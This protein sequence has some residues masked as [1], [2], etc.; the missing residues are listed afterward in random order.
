MLKKDR[1]YCDKFKLPDYKSGRA[2]YFYQYFLV[3][4]IMFF[5][6]KSA[7]YLLG[8]FL[9]FFDCANALEIVYPKSSNTVIDSPVT[10]FIGNE[11]VSKTLTI[12]GQNVKLHSTGAFKYP[13]KLNFGKNVFTIDNGSEQKVYTISR[14]QYI[15]SSYSQSEKPIFYDVP[16]IIT[17]TNDKTVLRSTPV[18][19]GLNRLQHLQSGTDMKAVGEYKGFYKVLLGRDNIAWVDK[20]Q[21]KI[22][23][24]KDL[25]NGFV[26]DFNYDLNNGDEVFKINT[27]GV[28]L[29][30]ILSEAS[31]GLDL[32]IYNMHNEIY[33]YGVYEYHIAHDGN[34][35]GYS[36]YYNDK[37]ELVIKVNKTH[38][39]LKD[40][41][42]TVDPGHGG[43]EYGAI[44]CLGHKEKDINLKIALNLREKLKSKGADVI[45]TRTNDKDV[46]LN[47]RV[48]IS[49]DNGAEIFISIHSNALPDSLLDKEIRGAEVY[50]FYPQAK[51]LARS[52]LKSI[53]TE[54]DMKD[55]GVKGESFA[56]V[57]NTNALSILI[58][59]GYI[60]DPE[61]NAR[62]INQDFQNKLTDAIIHG[63]EN[64]LNEL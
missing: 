23:D 64:Y 18:D 58:E 6:K 39:K 55:N 4:S 60:I 17:T 5:M 37:N 11:K 63:L 38:K 31:D 62:I 35:S 12:N 61:D 47:D 1:V 8:I 20:T 56:V 45:M 15:Q 28:R 43:R 24:K 57:R 41:K 27:E 16:K 2:L 54:T 29:P 22:S 40:L 3:C 48:K 53:S 36:S 25:E 21:V 32:A 9:L 46:S 26:R 51:K 7:L 30:Y 19:K 13:V 34:L 52:I 14:N 44:G 10:A 42:I 50:Y 59:V 49:N 33:P